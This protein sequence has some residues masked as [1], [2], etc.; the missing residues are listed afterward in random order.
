MGSNVSKT[1]QEATNEMI[2]KLD[3]TSKASATATCKIISGDITGED[4]ENCVVENINYCDASANAGMDAAVDAAVSAWNKAT[5]SQK[6]SLLP[7]LNVRDSSQINRSKI[8]EI[9][10]QKCTADSV[11]ANEII[12]GNINLRGCKNSSFKNLNTG[13]AKSDCAMK[14]VQKLISDTKA[15]SSGSQSGFDLASFMGGQGPSM[16]S[17]SSI[18]LI[19]CVVLIVV[20]FLGFQVIQNPEVIGEVGKI[21]AASQGVPV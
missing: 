19:V 6:T 9:L 14:A 20:A 7:S 16:S 1:Y 17:I 8:E 3:Q 21:A 18:I 13:Y 4:W 12:K 2:Q 11:S 5:D 15:D 10:N